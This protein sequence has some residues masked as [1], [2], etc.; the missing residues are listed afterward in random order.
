[1]GPA[2]R[3]HDPRW[4]FSPLSGAGAAHYGGRFNRRGRPALYLSL[5]IVTA[6]KE[7]AHGFARKLDPCVLCEYEVDCAPVAD[8]R[9]DSAREQMQV[10]LTELSGGWFAQAVADEEPAS[11]V[12]SEV[13][14][15][16]GYAGVLVPSFAPGAVA[17]DHNL[18]LWNWG[19]DLPTKV[20][21]YDP[22]QRLPRDQASWK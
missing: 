10:Q 16:R 12:L 8:L 2:F 4:S 20:R 1:M 18:V 21:V 5:R 7:V 9:T 17:A 11:W 6:I 22:H 15:A 3:A 13:L 14:I 19:P